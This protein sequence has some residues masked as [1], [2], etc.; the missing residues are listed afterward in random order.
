MPTTCLVSPT[1]KDLGELLGAISSSLCE[2]YGADVLAFV[3]R[4]VVGWQRK[5]IEDLL[6][7]LEDGRLAREL[8]LL[9][10][11]VTFP[12]L[13]L[14]GHPVFTNDGYLVRNGRPCRWS[15]RAWRN[16][17]RSIHYQFRVV[18]EHT[19]NI[20]DSAEAIR[21][22]L[23]WLLKDDHT[24]LLKRPKPID[25]WGMP[26]EGM[27]LHEFIL[28]G[29]PRVGPKTARAIV[30][31]FSRAPLYWTCTPQEMQEV[32]G[33][34]PITGKALFRVLEGVDTA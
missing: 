1:D 22:M 32:D 15:R 8:P 25:E 30:H 24:S 7:S 20:Q 18:V 17:L 34:G 27:A 29:F 19:Q 4:Q 28:Q 10:L 6:A 14:E 21:E 31:H 5:T 13:L 9:A 3:K 12:V 26:L 2:Q 11:K 23:Q 33:V 16:L